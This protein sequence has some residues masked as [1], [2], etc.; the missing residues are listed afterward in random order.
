[1][2]LNLIEPMTSACWVRMSI[3]GASAD[4]VLISHSPLAFGIASQVFGIARV[5]PVYYAFSLFSADATGASRN[6]DPLTAMA[7]FPATIIGH[8]LPSILMSTLPL[9]AT[10]VS[11][12]HFTLQSIVCYA[13]YLSPVTVSLLT[14]GISVGVRW[15][16]RKWSSKSTNVEATTEAQDAQ[17]NPDLPALKKTYSMMLAFQT[18]QH[19]Y[20][21][22]EALRMLLEA[23]APF[24]LHDRITLL[25]NA[26]S[27]FASFIVEAEQGS[28]H[29]LG[30]SLT[31]FM[32]ST[33]AFLLYTVWDLRRRGYITNREA[34]KA[35]LGLSATPIGP[36][37]AYAGFWLWRENILHSVPRL[38]DQS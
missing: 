22:A 1:M 7:A 2:S 12:S 35:C 3:S 4:L 37:A 27:G 15:L 6:V 32:S 31:L 16:R 14:K 21:A 19:L 38:R 11:R 34:V 36:G 10:E 30:S 5:A 25:M 17:I 24:S 13:L 23:L 28:A 29:A 20:F 33:L 8:V 9:T 18:A 26:R